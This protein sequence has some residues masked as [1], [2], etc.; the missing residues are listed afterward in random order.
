MR[1]VLFVW[2]CLLSAAGLKAQ[3][4]TGKV[5]F[6]HYTTGATAA[7]SDSIFTL[8]HNGSLS[9]VTLGYRPRLSHNGKLMAF[10]NGPN[11]NNSYGASIWMRD[12]VAMHDT[13][14]V[15]NGD[16]LDYYDFS[17]GDS[18]IVYSQS[19][20][21]YTANI[22]GTNAYH[23]INCAP[24]DCYSDDPTV[25]TID[26]AI[27]FHNVHYGIYTKNFDGSNVTAVPHT[28]PGDLY[29]VWSPDGRYIAY[30]KSITGSSYYT[31]NLY[32]IKFDG[33]DSAA[34]TYFPITDTIAPDPVWA[35]DMQTIFVIAR[36]SDTLG[37]YRI[38]ADGSGTYSRLYLFNP[39][40]SVFDYWMGLADS[41]SSTAV[42]VNV[43][44]SIHADFN[45]SA[46]AFTYSFTDLSTVNG[47]TV[48]SRSWNFGDSFS[49]PHD[50]SLLANPVHRFSSGGTYTVCE[51][52]TGSI[53]GATCTD[54][55][56]KTITVANICDSLV[57]LY[58]GTLSGQTGTFTNTSNATGGL[59]ITTNQWNF[60]DVASGVSD[61][62]SS[63]NATH[64]FTANGDHNV[65]LTVTALVNGGTDSCSAVYCQTFTI[66][67]V[68]IENINGAD[69]KLYPNPAKDEVLI[70]AGFVYSAVSLYDALGNELLKQQG[71]SNI[72]HLPSGISNGIYF[73]HFKTG[74]GNVVSSLAVFK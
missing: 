57:A 5:V 9:F 71:E 53:N 33:S 63:L 65:C 73:L 28:Y 38:A 56:C 14:I 17:P 30:L 47:G 50:T 40:G 24:C 64:T 52:I 8:D 43:C 18:Q 29:P 58:S 11:P 61:S 48:S 2:I 34:L 46:S 37:I 7:L 19:C 55:V 59:N 39:T 4:L 1:K 20:S 22:N 45:Y 25:N 31:D 16:Y 6:S 41:I 13:L 3:S 49:S 21:M 26:S 10:T 23:D 67:G 69:I 35:G 74:N 36:I 42:L 44:D 62:A 70:K 15:S 12:L 60:D 66:T 72:I 27:V 68:G 51:I 32:R 54:T